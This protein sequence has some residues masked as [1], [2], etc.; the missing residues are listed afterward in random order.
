MNFRD[1]QVEANLAQP[2]RF[3]AAVVE[4]ACMAYEARVRSAT[5]FN[6]AVQELLEAQIVAC[7]WHSAVESAQ[8]AMRQNM[9]SATVEAFNNTMTYAANAEAD[10]ERCRACVLTHY[11]GA[12]GLQVHADDAS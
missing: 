3:P 7:S 8:V 1:P 9:T 11:A 10:L 6:T 12:K 4:V 5:D 2:G